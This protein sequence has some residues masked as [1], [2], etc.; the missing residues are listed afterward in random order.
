MVVTAASPTAPPIWR[1]VL[2]RPEA[3]PAS[4]GWT[5]VMLAIVTGTKQSVSPMPPS[6]RPG[7]NVPE[8][9]SVRGHLRVERRRPGGEQ[10]AHAEHNAGAEPDGQR[11][12]DVGD[13]HQRG[14][15][16]DER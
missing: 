10:H 4:A 7:E 2:S 1:L 8:V 5:P 13:N 6:S 14:C 12:S 9:V 16:R 15:D 3:I 11:L